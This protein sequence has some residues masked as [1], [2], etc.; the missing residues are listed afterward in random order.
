[1][2]G[3]LK[4]L[5]EKESFRNPALP[6]GVFGEQRSSPSKTCPIEAEKKKVWRVSQKKM[7]PLREAILA[8]K[9]RLGFTEG[10]KDNKLASVRRQKDEEGEK[11]SVSHGL[12]KKSGGDLKTG[13]G[14]KG[15]EKRLPYGKSR[16][17]K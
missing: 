11:D 4:N 16:R 12:K 15:F 17:E 9:K 7:V 14:I 5:G 8:E 2:K 6:K 13:G 1:L 10:L 3:E